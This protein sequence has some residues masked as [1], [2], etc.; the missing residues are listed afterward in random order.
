MRANLTTCQVT[1][2]GGGTSIKHGDKI[3][4]APSGVQKELMKPTDMFVMDF[5]T[6]EYIRRPQV[7]PPPSNLTRLL[8]HECFRSTNPLPALHFSTRPLPEAPAAASTR[9]RNG[10]FLSP[11]LSNATLGPLP[12]SKSSRLSRSRASPGG[13]VK[14]AIWVTLKS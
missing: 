14:R 7:L 6:N 13:A 5:N 3:F 9:T 10:P 1:G 12:V 2:T 11:S 8:I 4:I